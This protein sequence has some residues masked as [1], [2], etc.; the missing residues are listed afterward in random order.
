MDYSQFLI[1]IIKIHDLK[2]VENI[3]MK[4]SLT[5]IECE[6]GFGG[7][8]QATYPQGLTGVNHEVIHNAG[9]ADS[10]WVSSSTTH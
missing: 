9:L 4:P 1:T 10:H 5:G 6:V 7:P 8:L 3:G 2:P